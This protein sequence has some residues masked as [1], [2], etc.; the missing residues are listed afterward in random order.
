M[1]K[2]QLLTIC[3]KFAEDFHGP[4]ETEKDKEVGN[5]LFKEANKPKT[6]AKKSQSH[7]HKRHKSSGQLLLGWVENLPPKDRPS[8]APVSLVNEGKFKNYFIYLITT[9]RI[10]YSSRENINTALFV[11]VCAALLSCVRKRK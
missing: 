9:N 3:G 10:T 1:G 8:L 6:E 5:K 7:K 4:R 11:H 2:Q